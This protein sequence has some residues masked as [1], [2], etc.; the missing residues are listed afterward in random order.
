MSTDERPAVVVAGSVHM[1]LIAGTDRLPKWGESVVGHSFAKVP[2]GK[3]GNQ[4]CQLATY[5]VE[6]FLIARLG[7]DAFGR[8]LREA[9]R[10]KGVD[11]HFVTPDS[12]T[13]TGAS[14]VLAGE[15]DYLS[16]IVPGAAAKLNKGDFAAAEPA[17][18][19][20]AALVVQLELPA[21]ISE[22]AARQASANGA[23]IV[24]N[25]SPL[26]APPDEAQLGLVHL[27]DVLVVNRVEAKA[28]LGKGGK[29]SGEPE[30]AARA[31]ADRF[32]TEL[33]VITLGAEG[34]IAL[35]GGEIHRQPAFPVEFVDTVGAGDAFLGVF[36]ACLVEAMS[37]PSA[38]RRATAAGAMAVGRRGA[39]DAF[40][41]REQIDAFLASFPS[42]VG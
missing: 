28:L 17:F 19:R 9:L 35:T 15:G 10:A 8:E 37:V 30:T 7:D 40:P 2:G 3:A 29:A 5:G 21:E 38:L 24:L 39:H 36:V 4:A 25:A 18:A 32:A 12:G 11:V 6:T 42:G 34:A 13:A 1:D 27:A 41:S 23:R 14:T 16:V 22:L 31:I 26:A 33:I 20:A